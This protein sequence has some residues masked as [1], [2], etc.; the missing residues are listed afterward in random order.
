MS[1]CGRYVRTYVRVQKKAGRQTGV[2]GEEESELMQHSF[3]VSF[4]SHVLLETNNNER[5][6][7]QK[8]TFL[9]LTMIHT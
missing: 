9:I 1:N 4:V 2:G 7:L 5:S 6:S 8:K 3:H